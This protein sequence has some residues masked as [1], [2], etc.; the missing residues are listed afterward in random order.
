MAVPATYTVK[1]AT[2]KDLAALRTIWSAAFCEDAVYTDFVL[3]NCLNLGIVLWVPAQK[4]CLTLLPIEYT[5]PDLAVKGY[6]VYGVATHPLS[7]KKGYSTALLQY[8][9]QWSL[10]NGAC[11]LL[12]TP[13]SKDLETFYRSRSFTFPVKVPVAEF[14]K[15]RPSDIPFSTNPALNLPKPV[16]C[17]IWPEPMYRFACEECAFRGG[18]ATTEALC[19]PCGEGWEIKSTVL[20]IPS[21]L[22]TQTA[23]VMDFHNCLNLNN[24]QG[25]FVLPLD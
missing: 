7:Q 19:Y 1:Q 8:A 22:K 3:T 23:L 2:E 12:L 18:F 10:D 21:T 9:T 14:S 17:F 25:N 16:N 4:S 11:F 15:E 20:P 13:A 6:Y 5:M 24:L